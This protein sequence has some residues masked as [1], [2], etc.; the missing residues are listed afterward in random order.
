MTDLPEVPTPVEPLLDALDHIMR[1]ARDGIQPTRRLDWIE[2]RARYALEGKQWS[3]D[4]RDTPDNSRLELLNK[5][6]K[7][8]DEVIALQAKLTQAESERDALKRKYGLSL[9]AIVELAEPREP[10][11]AVK[12]SIPVTDRESP[13]ASESGASPAAPT[14]LPPEP[15]R[16][17]WNDEPGRWI[18]ATD[19]DAL[20]AEL[21]EARDQVALQHMQLLSANNANREFIGA[22]LKLQAEL[23]AARKDVARYRWLREK[24]SRQAMTGKKHTGQIQVVQW[25]DR[26]T[27]NALTYTALDYAVD[28]ALAAI[29]DKK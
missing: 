19:Y 15:T 8:R 11:A 13:S 17:D 12:S 4:I 2:L 1:V 23:A 24:S 16:Y 22:M 6:K 20:Q 7:L 9:D 18:D 3:R 27:A 25:E 29:G 26:T 14:S 10:N 5:N 21:R 28:N